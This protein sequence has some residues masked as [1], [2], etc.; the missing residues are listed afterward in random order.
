M[1]KVKT[2]TAA[3]DKEIVEQFCKRHNITIDQFTGK[4]EVGGSLD[5][6]SLTSIPEGFNPTVGGSLY[7]RSLTSI[8]EGFNPTVGGSLYL[9]SLTSIPEGFNPTVGGSLDLGSLTSIPEGFN[10]TV[11]GSLDLRSLTSIPEGFNP[12][13]GGSLD[14]PYKFKGSVQVN[15]PETGFIEN[16]RRNK[17]LFWKDGQ[18]VKAD[19]IFTEVISKKGNLYKVKQENRSEGTSFLC[20]TF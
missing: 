1:K 7:L 2:T 11:G 16:L 19:G 3:V 12:T 17:L 14:L 10:P 8:P 6:R 20:S 9:E 18:Y 5:L 4:S 15:K 13:V